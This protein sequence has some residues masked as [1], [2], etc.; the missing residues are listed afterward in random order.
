MK[1]FRGKIKDEQVVLD[2]PSEWLQE[3]QRLNGEDI[4]LWLGKWYKPR[5]DAQNKYYWGVIVD[6]LIEHTGHDKEDIHTFLKGEHIPKVNILGRDVPASTKRM[7][8][9]EFEQYASRIRMWA[10]RELQV[11]IPEPNEAPSFA[12]DPEQ[13]I[14]DTKKKINLEQ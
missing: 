4:I 11:Y 12:Y 5:T 2:M 7:S 6:L 3:K 14:L 8:T 9:Q 13:E 1:W 10:S